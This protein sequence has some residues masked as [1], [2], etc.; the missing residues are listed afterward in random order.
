MYRGKLGVKHW[1]SLGV[2]AYLIGA[3]L[4]YF[5]LLKPISNR[6]EAIKT[7]KSTAEDYYLL[8]V[9]RQTVKEFRHHLVEPDEFNSI[10]SGVIDIAR[11]CNIR[12]LSI[13]P[14]SS[15]E[16]MGW[17]LVKIPIK[18][19]F[20]GTYHDIGSFINRIESSEK[21][22]IVDDLYISNE[23]D[24]KYKHKAGFILYVIRSVK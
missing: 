20:Q 6:V 21:L 15:E 11:R 2:V 16:K 3:N 23:T 8:N 5:F 19:Q 4:L 9:A 24:K 10:R 14:A 7:R 13:S 17:G 22:F 12:S 18:V 1:I